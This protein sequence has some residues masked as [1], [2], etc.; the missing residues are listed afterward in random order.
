M[1][2]IILIYIRMDRAFNKQIIDCLTES[3]L[4]DLTM[5]LDSA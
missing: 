3:E 2:N 4:S 5:V 1:Y